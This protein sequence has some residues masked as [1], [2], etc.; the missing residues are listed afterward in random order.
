[1]GKIPEKPPFSGLP[2]DTREIAFFGVRSGYRAPPRGV[3]VKPPLRQ[4]PGSWKK[5]VFWPKR[6]KRLEKAEKAHFGRFSGFLGVL[7]P[8]GD[9]RDRVPGGGFTSTPRAGALSPAGE[10]FPDPAP[11]RG[12]GS[13]EGGPGGLPLRRR[14]EGARCPWALAAAPV[15][16]YSSSKLALRTYKPKLNEKDLLTLP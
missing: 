14:P 1:L 5:A 13:P 4:G 12:G 11:K 9:L 8:L 15:L 10:G 6:P 2:G 16:L 7:G 3:D